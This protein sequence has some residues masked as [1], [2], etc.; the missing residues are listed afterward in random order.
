MELITRG[1]TAALIEAFANGAASLDRV[2]AWAGRVVAA[3]ET[4]I[5]DADAPVVAQVINVFED[6]SLD[7]LQLRKFA[8]DA[9]PILQSDLA[10]DRVSVLLDLLSRRDHMV[11]VFS[12]AA[13][14][15]ISSV[16]LGNALAKTGLPLPARRRLASQERTG[17]RKVATA[18]H[19]GDLKDLLEL[20]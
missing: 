14:G 19:S 4:D 5:V 7:E 10:A 18:L 6:D 15:T 20:V 12:L 17:Y 2:R 1:G 8:R 11:H 13:N 3:S 16:A 9:V